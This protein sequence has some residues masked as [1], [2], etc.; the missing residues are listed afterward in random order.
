[1]SKMIDLRGLNCGSNLLTNLDVSKSTLLESF[2][3]ENNQLTNLDVSKNI[4]LYKLDCSNNQL[5]NLDV[6]KNIKLFN[7]SCSNNLLT[8]LDLNNNKILSFLELNDNTLLTLFYIKILQDNTLGM[9]NCTGDCDMNLSNLPNLKYVCVNEGYEEKMKN[10]LNDYGYTCEVNTYCSFTP[11]GEFYTINGSTKICSSSFSYPHP[12]FS[13][14]SSDNKVAGYFIADKTGNYS[15]SIKAGTY[16]IT[17]KLENPE[18]YTVTPESITVSFPEQN[19]PYIKDFCFEPNGT[20]P[21]LEV[22]LLPKSVSR[23]GFDSYY[24]IVYKNKGNQVQSGS[25]TLNYDNTI[26]IYLQSTP[27]TTP[28]NGKL[29]WEFMDLL[30][31]ETLKISFSLKVNTPLQT[32][33]VNIEDILKYTVTITGSQTDETP[34]DNTFTLNETVVGS[35]DPND[36]TC[37]EGDVITPD[38]VGNYLHYRIRFENTGTYFAENIVVRDDIDSSVFDVSSIIPLSSSHDYTMR[39]NGNKVEFIFEGIKLPFEDDKNDG[40]VMF[41]IKTNPNL[42]LNTTVNNKASIYFDY[43]PAII[44]NTATTTVKENIGLGLNDFEFGD[45]F[46]LSPNPANEFINL[47]ANDNQAINKVELFN[48]QGQILNAVSG[49]MI[50]KIEISELPKGIYILQAHTSKGKTNTKFV[51]N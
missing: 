14:K 25:I 16:T 3:L 44:T 20:H 27:T 36:K 4:N 45:Y 47:K 12:K 30:P 8:S 15:T 48:T 42:T 1:V 51:K 26:L 28:L 31:N 13:L 10:I 41:K 6:S 32:P 49:E 18:Y 11:G 46:T 23:P 50:Q 7:L 22:T 29:T 39:V 2:S 21:D 37:L 33:E 35:Y 34:D 17:P 9:P 5:N 43:N 38:L 24:E 40:Y 19:S